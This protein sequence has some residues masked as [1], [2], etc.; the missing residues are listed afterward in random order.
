MVARALDSCG[1]PSG[2]I[3]SHITS[4]PSLRAPSGKIAT[5]FSI[6]SEL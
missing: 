5:G 4:A 6:Q 3:T 1:V 2:F